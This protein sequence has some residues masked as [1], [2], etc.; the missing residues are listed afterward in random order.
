MNNHLKNIDSTHHSDKWTIKAL[1]GLNIL[2]DDVEIK[3]IID[4]EPTTEIARAGMLAMA[5]DKLRVYNKSI[6]S[7]VIEKGTKELL[8]PPF[9]P[10]SSKQKREL[11]DWL[12]IEALS[13]S[14]TSGE[15][16]FPRSDLE[17][18]L[19]TTDEGDLKDLLQA[20]IDHSYSAIIKNNFI[21]AFKRYTIDG[22]LYGNLKLFGSKGFR[23]TSQNPNMLQFP[24]TGSIY[25]KP[26]KRCLIAPTGYVI[27]SADFGQLEERV[28]ASLSNDES[29]CAIFEDGL[30]SHCFNALIYFKDEISEHMKITGNSSIDAKLFKKLCS[31]NKELKAIRQKSKPINFKLNYQG[32]AD[33]DKGGNITQEIYDN[34]HNV[35]YKQVGEFR[36]E[37]LVKAREQG[38]VHLG[39]GCRLYSDNPDKDYRTLF[40]AYGGQFWSILTLLTINKLHS[41]LDKFDMN[42]DIK[43]IATIYD[44]IYFTVKEDAKTLKWLN[45]NLIELMT[46]D[47][48]EDQ[49]IKNVAEMVIGRNWSEEVE[50]PNTATESEIKSLL[51]TLS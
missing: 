44:S 39:L 25:A 17:I 15:A 19:K 13:T 6:D 32:M 33:A 12:G 31:T 7:K 51:L 20:F 5:K 46:K 8:L 26:L 29:K 3:K 40:N 43:C 47:F 4:G 21:A 48:L 16:S 30:D 27:A 45:D 28:L 1:K 22:I 2:L 23:L 35:L 41:L 34:Y 38:Y 42:E 18:M 49:R 11:F 24:S 36:D 9:N 14:K 10:A 50:I 37:M